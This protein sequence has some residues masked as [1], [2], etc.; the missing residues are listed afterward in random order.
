MSTT[1]LSLVLEM[2]R[3]DE[4]GDPYAFSFRPQKYLL[5]SEH[6]GYETVHIDWNESLLADLDAVRRPGR[7]T[8]VVAR[9]GEKLRGFLQP[10][11]W[12]Q[13]ESEIRKAVQTGRHVVLSM[14]FAA[15]ELYALPWELL[16]LKS[17]GQHLGKLSGVLLQYDWPEIE[18]VPE[19]TTERAHIGRILL[20]WSAAGGAVPAAEHVSAISAASRAA[21]LP[22]DPACDVLAHASYRRLSEVLGAAR[23]DGKPIGVVHLLCHG[24]AE[25]SG[26]G[27][28]LNGEDAEARVVGA[29]ALRRLLAPYADMVRLVVLC[30]CDSGNS[31]ALGNQVG[32]AAQALYRAGVAQVVASRFPLSVSGS[33]KLTQAL[34]EEFLGSHGSLLSALLLARQRLIEDDTQLDWASVQLYSRPSGGN[35]AAATLPVSD[36]VVRSGPP[37]MPAQPAE[38]EF[39]QG[40]EQVAMR[41]RYLREPVDSFVGRQSE[42]LQIVQRLRQAADGTT[43]GVSVI[44]GLGGS[45]KTEL[46]FKI[47][48]ALR[49]DFPMQFLVDLRGQ[50][51][52]PTSPQQ[53]LR[54]VLQPI[55]PIVRLPDDFDNLGQLYRES[56]GRIRALVLAD[57]A[58]DADHVLPLLPPAGC[59]L[60]I[61][62]RNR[63]DAGKL[64][65]NAYLDL[66]SLPRSDAA[67]LLLE[68]CD[69][70]TQAEAEALAER[71]GDLPKALQAAASLL[72]HDPTRRVAN[73]LT[74]LASYRNRLA[75]LRDPADS[76]LDVEAT[77]GMSYEALPDGIQMAL[78]QLSMMPASFDLAAA[79]AVLRVD[80][81]SSAG[82]AGAVRTLYQRCLVEWTKETDRYHLHDLVRAFALGRIDAVEADAAQSRHASH[83]R[84]KFAEAGYAYERGGDGLYFGLSWFDLEQEHLAAAQRWAAKCSSSDE[85]SARI[86]IDLSLRGE[87]LLRLRL[88]LSPKDRMV[89]H[90]AALQAA[91]W[92]GDQR[93]EG[94]ALG[95]LGVAYK[96]QG[97][98]HRAI[99]Y[100]EQSLTLAR[101]LGDHLNE[102]KVLGYLGNAY[103]DAG[104][105]DLAIA[106]CEQSLTLARA[107]G[108][109]RVEGAALNNL[110]NAHRDLGMLEQAHTCYE[111]V[112]AQSREMGDPIG[113]SIALGN[114]AE[115]LDRQGDRR[116]AIQLLEESLR[117]RERIS[118]PRTSRTR[119]KLN[120]WRA[121]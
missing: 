85:T 120:R 36:G 63:F 5:R 101:Q 62:T 23:R 79:E 47:A 40:S 37:L 71:C 31:G 64:K 74:D 35:V 72:A 33:I 43:T 34:Y 121:D 66:S 44:R 20:A 52:P 1:T 38:R 26:F 81:E 2:A 17:T 19:R 102:G 93:S 30:A 15:A 29:S 7:N 16:R 3:A 94:S 112:L 13:H 10:A 80:A 97:E 61:T 70:L 83:Y 86:C 113:E 99:D 28:L 114:L 111:Q 108:E 39:C 27:L 115:I 117:I 98:L 73:Y 18:T 89:W 96:N 82:G 51:A 54:Q 45:G 56:L 24:G 90:Q 106:C 58:R 88:R 118:D 4:A 67:Q 92:L 12:A 42:T 46:A 68:R 100:Y 8:S 9:L 77:L 109:R 53:A 116:E 110:G 104:R 60:L 14:R 65:R 103:S 59:V 6:G 48:A 91:R 76:D 119:D 50:S 105:A 69:R 107:V 75:H 25:G 95:N 11:G 78:C 49:S 21:S 84:N 87:N 22:F 55:F 32:S 41:S 57:D